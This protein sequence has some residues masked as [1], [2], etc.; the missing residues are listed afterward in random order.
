MTWQEVFSSRDKTISCRSNEFTCQERQIQMASSDN[1]RAERSRGDWRDG[2]A[3][4]YFEMRISLLFL[5]A[6]PAAWRGVARAR[7]GMAIFLPG[8]S[9]AC[10][11]I[12]GRCVWSLWRVL[13][14]LCSMQFATSKAWAIL[15][16]VGAIS[17]QTSRQRV[18]LFYIIFSTFFLRRRRRRFLVKA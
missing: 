2:V 17:P 4:D 6:T 5:E 3:R 15:S 8:A 16:K 11:S 10:P 14:F 7:H 1:V 18:I 9:P 12:V 13:C